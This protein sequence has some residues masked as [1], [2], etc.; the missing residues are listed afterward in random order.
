MCTICLSLRFL[1]VDFSS[2][3]KHHYIDQKIDIAQTTTT[4]GSQYFLARYLP[5]GQVPMEGYPKV[6][7]PRPCQVLMG[8]R[9]YS[10]VPTPSGPNWGEYPKV[11]TP[12]QGTY[13]PHR[14]RTVDGVDLLN[15]LQSLCILRSRITFIVNIANFEHLRQNNTNDATTMPNNM[16]TTNNMA[17]I[18]FQNSLTYISCIHGRCDCFK[19]KPLHEM[20]KL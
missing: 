15:K 3:L 10:K 19:E 13:P 16:K 12:D 1:H 18:V 14:D 20:S 2:V 9:G 5:P 8:G 17:F 6:S 4:K 11:P 7:T